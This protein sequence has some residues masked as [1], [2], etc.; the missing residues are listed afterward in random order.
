MSK[1]TI[2]NVTLLQTKVDFPLVQLL[3]I[4]KDRE[5]LLVDDLLTAILE[6]EKI[7]VSR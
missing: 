3:L 4:A 5:Y 2:E 6:A 7:W 1:H